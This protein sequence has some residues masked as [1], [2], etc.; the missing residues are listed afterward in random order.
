MADVLT[1]EFLRPIH[2]DAMSRLEGMGLGSSVDGRLTCRGMAVRRWVMSGAERA[3]SEVAKL[4]EQ[5][6]PT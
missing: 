6:W 4:L 5:P 2:P 3:P 1:G